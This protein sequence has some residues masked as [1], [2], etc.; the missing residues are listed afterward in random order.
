MPRFFIPDTPGDIVRL[1]GEQARHI[2]RSLRMKPG[3]TLTLCDGKGFDYN[4]IIRQAGDTVTLQVLEKCPVSSEPGVFLHLYQALPKGD[5]MDWIIQ[6]SVELGASLITPVITSRCISRPTPDAFEKKRLRY[7]KIA[8]EAAKQS[9]RGI[10]PTV[11]P[12]LTF[13]QALQELEPKTRSVLFYECG[14]QSVRDLISQ[15]EKRV[16]FFVGSEGGFSPDEVKQA[17][18]A[19]VSLASLGSRILRCETAPLC[20]LS[21]FLYATGNI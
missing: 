4:C 3:E 14:G 6:K 16:S 7:Q 2:A 11:T 12:L 21:L 17:E 13:A 5:K 8:Q 15:E 10:I 19:G 18:S 20:A 9:G 1:E